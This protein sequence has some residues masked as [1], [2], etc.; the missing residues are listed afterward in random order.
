[1]KNEHNEKKELTR[2]ES[3]IARDVLTEMEAVIRNRASAIMAEY[4]R[5]VKTEEDGRLGVLENLFAAIQ[6]VD[7]I[8]RDLGIIN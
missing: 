1:M 3:R 7:S 2:L 8:A 6:T 4:G 5:H